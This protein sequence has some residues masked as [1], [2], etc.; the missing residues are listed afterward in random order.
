M[1]QGI[2]LSKTVTSRTAIVRD[3][4][5]KS[6]VEDSDRD[7]LNNNLKIQK[8]CNY[9]ARGSLLLIF[10]SLYK[11]KSFDRPSK[12]FLNEIGLAFTCLV[13]LSIL[14]YGANEYMWRNSHNILNKYGVYSKGNYIDKKSYENMRSTYQKQKK[15]LEEMK[16][17]KPNNEKLYD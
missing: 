9:S 1:N 6:A 7:I 11:K 3:T 5:C 14:D 8:Y 17:E 2:F 15:I 16:Y 10:Y 13:Y 12:F 4:I